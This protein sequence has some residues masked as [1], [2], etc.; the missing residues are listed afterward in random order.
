MIGSDLIR[1]LDKKFKITPITRENYQ[2]HIRSSFDIIIN[3]N[4][5]SKR[6]WANQN[7]LKD[8]S[9]STV[10]VYNSLFDFSCKTYIY[11]SSLDVYEKHSNPKF[12]KEEGIVDPSK[13]QPYG[14][15]KYMSE[16]IVKKYNKRYLILRCPLVL[17]KNL[18]KGPIF[19][20]LQ[21]NPLFVT[22]ETKLTLIT[23]QAIAEIIEIL[24]KKTVLNQTINIGGIGTFS[25]KKAQK[26][27]NKKIHVLD[28]TE[29]QV[30]TINVD[31]IKKLYPT[32]KSSEEYL[33]NYLKD[34][35]K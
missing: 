4:G 23:T 25:F 29:K 30:Y 21:N 15:N 16:L 20:I 17:G 9:A 2:T 3:A 33:Q 10:S 6:F 5:N 13:L 11:I 27:F 19:D 34:Y 26:Y 7:P 28:K 22:H 31:K 18:K 32:L 24:I 35:I 8:F 14:F 1:Y 12:T